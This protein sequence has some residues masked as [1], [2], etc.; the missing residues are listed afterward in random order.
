MWIFFYKIFHIAKRKTC[1]NINKNNKIYN[2][3]SD[4]QTVSSLILNNKIKP[5]VGPLCQKKLSYKNKTLNYRALSTEIIK[6]SKKKPEEVVHHFL[7]DLN[8]VHKSPN[9]TILDCNFFDFLNIRKIFRKGLKQ[10]SGIYM[11]KY[12]HDNRL[13]YIGKSINLSIRLADHYARSEFSSSR[14]GI[15]L[16]NGRLI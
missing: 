6:S 3:G 1:F 10:K 7:K 14:L 2:T 12:K 4:L 15:F 16:K 8:V 9:K 11:L 5:G 13:F